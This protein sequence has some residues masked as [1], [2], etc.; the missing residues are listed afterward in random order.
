MNDIHDIN[1]TG[2]TFSVLGA[3]KVI[4][5]ELKRELLWSYIILK[6]LTKGT[7][8]LTLAPFA[9]SNYKKQQALNSVLMHSN[10]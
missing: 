3:V 1:F 2:S 4:R 9:V 7:V 6:H 10:V 8:V 5:N